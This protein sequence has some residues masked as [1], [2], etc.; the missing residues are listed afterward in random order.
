MK[1]NDDD[2]RCKAKPNNASYLDSLGWV[3]FRKGQF[4]ERWPNCVR[5]Q[6]LPQREER[7]LNTSVKN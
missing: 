7:L 4:V 6:G 2:A 1:L 5:L 3:E